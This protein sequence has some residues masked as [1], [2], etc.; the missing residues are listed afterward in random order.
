MRGVWSHHVDD[1]DGYTVLGIIDVSYLRG[2]CTPGESEG[3]QG[4]LSQSS[5][6]CE[7]LSSD[8]ELNALTPDR[9]VRLLRRHLPIQLLAPPDAHSLPTV[10]ITCVVLLLLYRTS[11]NILTVHKRT[12]DDPVKMHI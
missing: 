2:L 6:R 8:R 1:F 7:G 4:E 10:V 9:P 11:P 3:L 5:G 12:S